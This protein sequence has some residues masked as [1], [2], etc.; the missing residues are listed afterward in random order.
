MVRIINEMNA[1]QGKKYTSRNIEKELK[2]IYPYKPTPQDKELFPQLLKNYFNSSITNLYSK[3]SPPTSDDDAWKDYEVSLPIDKSISIRATFRELA[4]LRNMLN[5]PS[6]R[7]LIEE[8]LRT[9]LLDNLKNVP[10]NSED[11]LWLPVYIRE[12]ASQN[13]AYKEK[14]Y[15]IWHAMLERH[16]IYYENVTGAGSIKKGIV[17]PCR[18]EYDCA[19]D[20]Y[21]LIAWLFEENR[22]IKILIERIKNVKVLEIHFDDNTYKAFQES[23]D[24]KKTSCELQLYNR[25]NTNALVRFYSCFEGYDKE[26]HQD[27]TYKELYHITLHY[28]EFDEHLIRN[29]ILSLTPHL[30]VVNPEDVSKSI[31]IDNYNNQKK[32]FKKIAE[33]IKKS[34]NNM[35]FRSGD[36]G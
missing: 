26:T 11:N 19:Y 30:Q 24:K 32:L 17:A 16:Q 28:Y 2:S 3:D 8:K 25:E 14:L 31:S 13:E 20:K 35:C 7:F 29:A 10:D 18:L 1:S 12:N 23:L 6:A 27:E 22:P 21:A 15:I 9:K 34:Y 33:I 5:N 4:W 36:D